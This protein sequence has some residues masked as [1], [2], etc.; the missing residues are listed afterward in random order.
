VAAKAGEAVDDIP[1][2]RQ[3][4]WPKVARQEIPEIQVTRELFEGAK[5]EDMDSWS[6]N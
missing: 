4:C 2:R 3:V 1:V 5:V 6:Y